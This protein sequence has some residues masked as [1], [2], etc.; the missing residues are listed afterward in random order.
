[1]S[2]EINFFRGPVSI[3]WDWEGPRRLAFGNPILEIALRTF[4]LF[5]AIFTLP[6]YFFCLGLRILFCCCRLP[7]RFTLP[8]LRIERRPHW[9]DLRITNSEIQASCHS[10]QQLRSLA[11]TPSW[12]L[13]KQL[14]SDQRYLVAGRYTYSYYS[15][16]YFSFKSTL[17]KEFENRLQFHPDLSEARGAIRE[18]VEIQEK[19]VSVQWFREILKRGS[20]DLTA[21]EWRD[22]ATFDE[23]LHYIAREHGCT[24]AQDPRAFGRGVLRTQRYNGKIDQALLSMI[25]FL[26]GA[27]SANRIPPMNPVVSF[28]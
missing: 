8:F 22:P 20:A 25:Q 6:I 5:V 11:E 28:S 13:Y 12:A 7:L 3:D 15:G 2:L 26:G 24:T 23:V 4:S 16:W 17:M 27:Y 1:M 14:P 18:A 21:L 10:L 9:E 19:I